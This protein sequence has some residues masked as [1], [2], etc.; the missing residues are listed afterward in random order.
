MEV[1]KM[2]AIKFVPAFVFALTFGE[3]G[4]LIF[5]NKWVGGLLGVLMGFGFGYLVGVIVVKLEMT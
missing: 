4:R 1:R 3:V 5:P 2:E